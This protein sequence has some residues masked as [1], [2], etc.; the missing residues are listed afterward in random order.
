MERYDESYLNRLASPAIYLKETLDIEDEVS[1]AEREKILESFRNDTP[2]IFFS[3]LWTHT[4]RLLILFLF[5]K[6]L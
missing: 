1:T 4:Q 2:R 5:I 3:L 6:F